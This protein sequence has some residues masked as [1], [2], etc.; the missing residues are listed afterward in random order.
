MKAKRPAFSRTAKSAIKKNKPEIVV[1]TGTK[2]ED[3]TTVF[4]ISDPEHGTTVV[5]LADL[6]SFEHYDRV[7][8]NVRVLK[9]NEPVTVGSTNTAKQLCIISDD[10]GQA[11]LVLWNDKVGTFVENKSYTL[12]RFQAT[13]F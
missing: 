8:T 3:S 13:R 11:Q 9:V 12:H 4:N 1:K 2:I 10:S 5:N 6:H 7:T